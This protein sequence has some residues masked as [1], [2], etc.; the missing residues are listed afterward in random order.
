MAD[1]ML[2][3]DAALNPKDVCAFLGIKGSELIHI[4]H[5]VRPTIPAHAKGAKSKWSPQDVVRAMFVVRLRDFGILPH[6]RA[7][8][9]ARLDVESFH[10][11]YFH[12][13]FLYGLVFSGGF[14]V[15]EIEERQLHITLKNGPPM[16][17]FNI[18]DFLNYEIQRLYLFLVRGREQ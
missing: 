4:T 2:P 8:F 17:L 10:K 12:N 3:H 1:L 18:H 16:I 9:L 14:K 15:D 13:F 7:S 5:E 11:Y 6:Q